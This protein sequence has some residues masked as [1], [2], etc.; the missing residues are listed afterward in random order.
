MAKQFFLTQ[1]VVAGMLNSTGL[2][3]AL[4]ASPKIRLYSGTVPSNADAALSSNTQLAELTCASSPFASYSDTG[5]AARAV[6]GTITADSSA[7]ATG[8]ATFFRILNSAGDTVKAQGTVGTTDADLILN[9]TSI[10]LGS[11]VAITS[12]YIELPEG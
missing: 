8:T 3:E 10:T 2:A 9:T 1:A 7:D 11:T 6:F 5:S 12:A 4:G